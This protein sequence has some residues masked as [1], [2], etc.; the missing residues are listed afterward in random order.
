MYCF[1]DLH[2]HIVVPYFCNMLH[3]AQPTQG[4]A[5]KRKCGQE[6]TKHNTASQS[7]SVLSYDCITIATATTAVAR[8]TAAAM[9]PLLLLLAFTNSISS[10]SAQ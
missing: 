3:N 8:V 2:I 7:P 10:P 6:Y 4:R 9:Q 5:N 1:N